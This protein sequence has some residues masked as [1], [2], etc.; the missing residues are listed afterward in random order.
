MSSLGLECPGWDSV[1]FL[2]FFVFL[3]VVVVDVAVVDFLLAAVAAAAVLP[4][5]SLSQLIILFL[6]AVPLVSLALFAP[7]LS[8]N[9]VP[10]FMASEVVAS[11]GVAFGLVASEVVAFEVVDANPRIDLLSSASDCGSHI[12]EDDVSYDEP[13]EEPSELDASMS[14]FSIDGG[15]V[16]RRRVE[17]SPPMSVSG[18]GSEARLSITSWVNP[19]PE[20]IDS[21]W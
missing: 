19:I 11:E 18:A 2:L 9:Q 7:P 8:S 14:G 6:S 17:N 21:N 3:F 20:S 13:G 5:S 15:D 12:E 4:C 16:K 1:L 10:A